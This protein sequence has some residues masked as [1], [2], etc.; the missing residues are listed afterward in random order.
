M[1]FHG[2]FCIVFLRFFDSI[3]SI[4]VSI[5]SILRPRV[6][7]D[8]P[9]MRTDCMEEAQASKAIART[10]WSAKTS[11]SF[12]AIPRPARLGPVRDGVGMCSGRV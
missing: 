11:Y 12:K 2:V 6:V 3:D 5:R 9:V 7:V 10:T 8:R 4:F 1:S